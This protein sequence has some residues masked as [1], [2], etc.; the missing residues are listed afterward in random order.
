MTR[1]EHEESEEAKVSSDG[2]VVSVVQL[3]VSRVERVQS[4]EN[5]YRGQMWYTEHEYSERG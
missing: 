5:I 4:R 2:G 1:E 3:A